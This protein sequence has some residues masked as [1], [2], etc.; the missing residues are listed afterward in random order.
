MRDPRQARDNHAKGFAVGETHSRPDLRRR[1]VLTV[2][3]AKTAPHPSGANP[4][5]YVACNRLACACLHVTPIVRVR[6]SQRTV[7]IL[8]VYII[9]NSLV[10]IIVFQSPSR[11]RRTSIS[12]NHDPGNTPSQRTPPP[13][14]LTNSTQNSVIRDT[15]HPRSRTRGVTSPE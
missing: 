5:G 7:V 4:V 2:V 11:A 6:P 14:L 8:V 15:R 1:R 12:T 10:I 3:V 9:S 13:T